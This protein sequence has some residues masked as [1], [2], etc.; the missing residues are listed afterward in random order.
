MNHKNNTEK[1]R[2]GKRSLTSILAMI[3]IAA[4]IYFFNLEDIDEVDRTGFIPV[5]LV[6]TID[7]DTI[8]ILYEGKEQNVRYLLIDTPE[9]DHKQ[10]NHQPFAEEAT[11]RNDELL[12]SGNVEIEFDVGDSEDK[13]GRLLAYVYVDG[14]SVQQTLLE[15]GLA[16]VAYIYEPNTKHLSSFK[17]AEDKAENDGLG[18][19]SIEGYVTNRGFKSV[20]N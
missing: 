16:R 3:V 15:E 2:K 18:V 8:K 19:W 12:R 11:K 17:E 10:S 20:A 5:E 9:L 4:V 7:G 1:S 14:E 6:H 13:Y